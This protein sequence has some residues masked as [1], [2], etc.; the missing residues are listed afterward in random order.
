[1]WS[2]GIEL[3]TP[4]RAGSILNLF[5]CFQGLLNLDFLCKQSI[6]DQSP[7]GERG[8]WQDFRPLLSQSFLKIPTNLFLFRN[9]EGSTGDEPGTPRFYSFKKIIQS[10]SLYSC[11][12]LFQ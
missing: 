6:P 5:C 2:L 3:A 1:M 8:Y 9:I 10:L 7:K 4:A 11:S 12:L